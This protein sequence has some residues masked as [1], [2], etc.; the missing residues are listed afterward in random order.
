MRCHL[1]L[2]LR[3]AAPTL[4]SCA[5]VAGCATAPVD[6]P[7]L[8]AARAAYA[9]ARGDPYASRAAAVELDRSQQALRAAEAT[10]A[11]DDEQRRHL[12]YLAVRHAQVAL[13]MGQ[14]VQA[15]EGVQQAAATRERLRLQARTREAEQAAQQARSAQADA[16]VAQA[17][18]Q[19][20]QAQARLEA[21]RAAQA[22]LQLR[23]E[24]ERA[25]QLERDLQALQG[26]VTERGMVVTLGDVLFATGRDE[27]QPA[28]R[29][30]A[31]QLATVMR[32]Y[33][34]RRVLIEGF[35]DSV[36][37]EQ[38]N[39]E[40]SRRRAEAFREALLMEGVSPQRIE[41]QAHGEGFPVADNGTPA[42]RQE[43]RRVEVLFS[44]GQGR[45]ATR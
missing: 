5:L 44:D 23:L 12:A 14:Q 9:Q 35:T 42:G 18:A 7:E 4:L 31:Q 30:T 3:R 39:L 1:A 24:A 16:R 36:G 11:R 37:S 10:S 2:T 45:F 41:L 22:Q 8:R 43:N 34:E 40:L 13:A 6:S 26:R 33:P 32:Q 28:A 17:D 19:Q 27:L 38:T 15:E 20:A 29:R 25:A 21:D